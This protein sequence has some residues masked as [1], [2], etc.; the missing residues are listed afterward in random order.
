VG[1]HPSRWTDVLSLSLSF[2]LSSCSRKQ[3]ALKEKRKRTSLVPNRYVVFFLLFLLLFFLL[4]T[5]NKHKSTIQSLINTIKLS[6]EKYTASSTH[7]CSPLI[8]PS[9]G[10][11][12]QI[13]SLTLNLNLQLKTLG[14]YSNLY[15]WHSFSGYYNMVYLKLE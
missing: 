7:W 2:L 13:F 3:R 6:N 11:K 4:K 5:K 10:S 15:L 8:Y 14:L 12:S 9:N 1:Q